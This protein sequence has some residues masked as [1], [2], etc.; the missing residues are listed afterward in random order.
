MKDYCWVLSLS[1][2]EQQSHFKK[3]CMAGHVQTLSLKLHSFQWTIAFHEAYIFHKEHN[4]VFKWYLQ[5]EVWLVLWTITLTRC[6]RNF[7]PWMALRK[8]WLTWQGILTRALLFL[9][10][11]CHWILDNR[12]YK[13]SQILNLWLREWSYTQNACSWFIPLTI[14]LIDNKCLY[15]RIACPDLCESNSEIYACWCLRGLQKLVCITITVHYRLLLDHCQS[16]F[17]HKL[18]TKCE[19]HWMQW[20]LHCFQSNLCKQ[21][22]DHTPYYASNP[23]HFHCNL[24]RTT[25]YYSNFCWQESR[26]IF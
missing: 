7:S 24:L 21:I 23:S 4:R 18:L 19:I 16:N 10:S 13:A 3:V 9:E 17:P 26:Y 20:R 12:I 14:Q 8:I 15:F 1:L 11:L 2:R 22:L 6:W 5:N 25:H